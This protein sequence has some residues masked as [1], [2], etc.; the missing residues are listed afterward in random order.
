MTQ[1]IGI[2]W[3]RK[4]QWD[5]LR[6]ISTD[7]S[8][9]EFTFEEW[10]ANAE[11]MLVDLRAQGL[12]AFKYEVDVEK[13]L[14]WCRAKKIQVNGSTRSQYVTEKLSLDDRVN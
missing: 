8:N 4:E 12:D 13:L 3:Y 1:K 5:R 9:L 2:A 14:E 11:K 6:E 7:K 10:L